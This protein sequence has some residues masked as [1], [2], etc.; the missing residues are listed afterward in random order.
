[1]A[2]NWLNMLRSCCKLLAKSSRGEV[3]AMAAMQAPP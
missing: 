3:D 2:N 1:M